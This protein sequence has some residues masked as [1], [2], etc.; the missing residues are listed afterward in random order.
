[1]AQGF[2]G[3]FASADGLR[4]LSLEDELTIPEVTPAKAPSELKSTP[5]KA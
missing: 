2:H 1:L 4:N 5:A 3:D